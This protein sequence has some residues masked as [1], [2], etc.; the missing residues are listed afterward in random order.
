[1]RTA[2]P[3]SLTIELALLGFVHEC[4][5]HGYEIY[6]QLS[7]PVGLWQVWRLKQSQLYAL[8]TKLEEVGYLAA[9]LQPQDAR[10]PR[11]IYSL[12]EGGRAAFLR[13]LHSPVAHGRQMRVEFLAKLYFA[14]RQTP[15]VALQLVEQQLAT[16]ERWRVEFRTQMETASQPQP[17]TYAVHQFRLSQIDSFLAWLTTCRQALLAPVEHE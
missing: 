5:V 1:M 14:Y 16:C 6:H 3:S 17:F 9:T 13:W 4:P 12:T 7:D 8:L 2:A 10:P 15:G 11:K